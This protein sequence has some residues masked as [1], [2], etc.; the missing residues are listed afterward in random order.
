MAS[1]PGGVSASMDPH[2]FACAGCHHPHTSSEPPPTWLPTCTA[3]GCHPKAWTETIFH[4]VDP[5]IFKD[6]THCHVPHVWKA[7]GADCRSCHG[8]GASATPVAVQAMAAFP[9]ER[10]AG[11]E[12]TVCH[13]TTDSHASLIVTADAQ[14]QACHHT[15]PVADNCATCHS[16]SEIAG[17][18]VEA[19]SMKLSRSGPVRKRSLDFDHSR[20]TSLDCKSCHSAPFDAAPRVDCASCH[21]NH[22]K[23]D[24]QCQACHQPPPP[25]VHPLSVHET[26]CAACHATP[27]FESMAGSRNLCLS[28]HRTLENHQP[29]KACSTCHLVTMGHRKSGS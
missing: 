4:R 5:E 23:I 12:C 3:S 2:P 27:G 6:C 29:G 20:H 15:P 21:D 28:C 26:G 24:A 10:H 19:V 14:C 22:H 11:F 7:V 8:P 18:R 25:G 17:R 16:G 13:E 9:H 1:E